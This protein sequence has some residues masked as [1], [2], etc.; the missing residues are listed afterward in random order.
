MIQEKQVGIKGIPVWSL[1]PV[2]KR[3][4]S[5]CSIMAGRRR[6]NSRPSAAASW[7]PMATTSSF[8]TRQ[9]WATVHASDYESK[10]V[11]S[12]FLADHLPEPDGS[13]GHAGI[14]T[15]KLVR[16]AHRRHGSFHGRL[17]GLRGCEPFQGI[18]DGCRHE[19]HRLGLDHCPPFSL[20]S[21]GTI[22][23]KKVNLM[24]AGS[25]FSFAIQLTANQDF[26]ETKNAG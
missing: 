22:Q 2:K 11:Y 26:V 20:R 7:L 10:V 6:K 13:T 4:A 15:G 16:Y 21:G 14:Y 12:P 24:F 17:H 1:R 19:R 9:P 5:S 18:Q 3:K 8:P 23:V 25:E